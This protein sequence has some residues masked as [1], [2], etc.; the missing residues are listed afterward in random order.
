MN[1]INKTIKNCLKLYIFDKNAVKELV[2]KTKWTTPL[3]I[4]FIVILIQNIFN[5]IWDITNEIA[6]VKYLVLLYILITIGNLLGIFLASFIMHVLLKIVGS[7]K[8]Y[9][10]TVKIYSSIAF[11]PAIL[12]TILTIPMLGIDFE[13]L[14]ETTIMIIGTL[15]LLLFIPLFVYYMFVLVRTFSIAHKLSYLQTITALILIPLALLALFI[16]LVIIFSIIMI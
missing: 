15:S 12:S 6:E 4:L 16:I 1:N 9:L 5:F 13:T 10:N 8:Q 11:V 2:S 3:I 14:D 7:T